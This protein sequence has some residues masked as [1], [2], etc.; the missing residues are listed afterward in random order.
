MP[1]TYFGKRF[2]INVNEISVILTC[3]KRP[4]TLEKQ[5]EAI[6]YQSVKPKE[7]FIFI[8]SSNRFND[9][10][11]SLFNQFPTWISNYNSGVWGRFSFALQSNGDYIC[12]FD[13]DT[14]PGKKW[15]ENCLIE[16][17]KE[18]ALYGTIG[19]IFNDL[20]YRSYERH[21]WANPNE[22]KIQV[23]IVG[24]SWFFPKKYLVSFWKNIKSPHNI[25]CGEDVNLSYSI[26]RDFQARTL[27]PPHP[28]NNT[29]MWGSQPET[30][31]KY[32]IDGAA[33]SVNYHQTIFGD[34]LK[35]Y[36]N[37]G[38]KFLRVK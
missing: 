32:G 30:A 28:K 25:L 22:E 36:Y 12:I 15:L 24:H 18:E 10:D 34:S 17:K 6:K 1:L 29:E 21:G 14:I 2:R 11:F 27:V 31:N 16:S 35:Y 8:N 23:D 19:V 7:V 9:F 33:I 20:D 37:K 5:I 13:D 4:H 38:F 3:F 26:Q